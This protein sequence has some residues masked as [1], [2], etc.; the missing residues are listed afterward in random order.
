MRWRPGVT[1]ERG[2][3][4][5]RGLITR[6]GAD[7]GGSANGR[8]ARICWLA[9][10]GRVTPLAGDATRRA[11]LCDAGRT[12]H[13]TLLPRARGCRRGRLRLEAFSPERG[14]MGGRH[15]PGQVR[16]CV[17]GLQPGSSWALH[18]PG[19]AVSWPCARARFLQPGVGAQLLFKLAGGISTPACRCSPFPAQQPTMAPTT[20]KAAAGAQQADLHVRA[21]PA[22]QSDRAAAAPRRPQYSVIVPTY[23]EVENVG[24]LLWMLH[25]HGRPSWAWPTRRSWWTTAA[26]TARR[27]RSA[28]CRRATRWGPPGSS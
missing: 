20:R 21:G 11:L 7:R 15:Q 23:N 4:E 2:G 27:T 26:R 17:G 6:A 5:G 8:R 13:G 12:S 24:V 1:A 25:A 28:R 18:Q 19:P 16:A 22:L 10:G 3:H 9:G 14:R